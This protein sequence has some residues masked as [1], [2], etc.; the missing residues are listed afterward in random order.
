MAGE[1]SLR[2]LYYKIGANGR[3]KAAETLQ[4]ILAQDG[5]RATLLTP[6]A[7]D[8][9]ENTLS[10]MI[11]DGYFD[12]FYSGDTPRGEFTKVVLDAI[13]KATESAEQRVA[14]LTAAN[15]L[16][17]T[18][19]HKAIRFGGDVAVFGMLAERLQKWG[20]DDAA[21]AFL[22]NFLDSKLG[23]IDHDMSNALQD[24]RDIRPWQSPEAVKIDTLCNDG[25]QPASYEGLKQAVDLARPLIIEW[26][27]KHAA[28]PKKSEYQ[29]GKEQKMRAFA[30]DPDCVKVDGT[31]VTQA[32]PGPVFEYLLNLEQKFAPV[33]PEQQ[34]ERI[35]VQLSRQDAA[36]NT[37]MHRSWQHSV[38]MSSPDSAGEVQDR[39]GAFIASLDRMLGTD[40]AT[41]L[42]KNLLLM[43]N[44]KGELPLDHFPYDEQPRRDYCIDAFLRD[45][46]RELGGKEK[47]VT[48][49][50]EAVAA[51]LP[52]D[53]TI[54]VNAYEP[55]PEVKEDDGPPKPKRGASLDF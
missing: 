38:F 4:N 23:A 7:P 30:E 48:Y 31:P 50:K 43:E 17:Q 15:D 16:G 14:I 2:D 20:G 37:P 49:L 51:L 12:S 25:Y 21:R 13:E 42:V 52:S 34:A 10:Y 39:L 27:D 18:P 33:P 24:V 32:F 11:S 44:S 8:V 26:L 9:T 1:K 3:D 45:L 53:F 54:K 41:G 47:F 36:G 6:L 19:F 55:P 22:E 46:R 40:V 5:M 35:L 28:D 29:R